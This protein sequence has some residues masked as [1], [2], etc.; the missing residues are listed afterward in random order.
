MKTMLGERQRFFH[1]STIADTYRFK[2]SMW[3]ND[4][5]VLFEYNGD[6]VIVEIYIHHGIS[7]VNS[8]LN[9]SLKMYLYISYSIQYM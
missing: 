1:T 9:I 8:G 2:S 4:L 7:N 6:L 3:I 5:K